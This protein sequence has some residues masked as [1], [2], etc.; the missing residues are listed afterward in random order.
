MAIGCPRVIPPC[1][2]TGRI[3]LDLEVMD[4]D[5]EGSRIR[6]LKVPILEEPACYPW[7]RR[8]FWF[9]DPDGRIVHLFSDLH[10]RVSRA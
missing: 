4:V 5:Q 6:N 7:C 3:S 2:G 1:G 9:R 10:R 8:S